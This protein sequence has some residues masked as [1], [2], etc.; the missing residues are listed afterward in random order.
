MEKSSN[1]IS[2]G[3]TLNSDFYLRN[4]YRANRTAYKTSGRKDLTKNE[5]S[6]EDAR[7][8]RH[9]ARQLEAH[10]FDLDN[11]TKSELFGRVSAYIKTYN[12]AIDSTEGTDS[13]A[14]KKYSKQL[15]KLVSKHEDELKGL[16]ITLDE[17]GKLNLSEQIF[18]GASVEKVK[19]V[20]SKDSSF[21]NALDKAAKKLQNASYQTLYAELTGTGRIL[22]ITL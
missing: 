2:T 4:Y 10:N 7:A 21:A 16:G 6:Y 19:K 8:L 14:I 18:T 13:D 17:S 9:A 5:L 12:N 11:D 22:N 15:K 1:R 20:F 3:T